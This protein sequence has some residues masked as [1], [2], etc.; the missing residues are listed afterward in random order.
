M[1]G[2][3]AKAMSGTVNAFLQ[4]V[5]RLES[6]ANG[7]RS[8]GLKSLRRAAFAWV[9]EH[10]FPTVKDEAWKYTR[11]APILE[12]PFA[13]AEPDARCALS[14]GD[15][16]ELAGEL[17]GPRLVF[18]NG[19]FV[20]ALSALKNLPAGVRLSSL[21]TVPAEE[22]DA[23]ESLL[24]WRLFGERPQAFAALNM[25]LGQDG[26]FIRIPARTTVEEPIHLVYLSDAGATPLVSHP[27]SV[28]F[29][30][31]G[32]RATIVETHA[33][34]AGGIYLTN[35]VTQIV[36]DEGAVVEHYKIQNE[37]EAAFHFASMD[38]RQGRAS[39][40]SAHSVAAGAV[41]A[42]HEVKV[43]LE[44]PE[45]QVALNGLYLPRDRQLLDNP[46]MVEHAAPHCTSRQLYKGVVDGHGRGVFDGRIVVQPGAMKTDAK[47]TN[48]NL[49]LSESAQA[50]TRPRLEIFADDVKCAHGAAVG[51][52][53]DEALYYLR[54][55]GIPLQAARNLLTYA[56]ASEMLE[57]IQVPQLRSRVQQILATRLIHV[58][59]AGL[60]T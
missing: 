30:G 14:L 4:R 35:A 6:K 9:G 49:L 50:Y 41:L 45:A 38:V 52:L 20:P 37:A 60:P 29:A 11:V 17:G 58:E 31:A 32:S 21:A 7:H 51:Q 10:G 2:S 1:S 47:Q 54:T 27:L 13:P 48:K 15:V 8:S 39:R 40:F 3:R 5:S 46:T 16:T 57:L 24:R 56:F 26:A 53:D 23:L 25:A 36:L 12:I 28:V 33:G 42:R 18:V 44:A 59:K 55:R 34:I 22:A 19:Y 43:T